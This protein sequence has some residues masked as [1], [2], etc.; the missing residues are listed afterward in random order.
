MSGCTTQYQICRTFCWDS[1]RLV[2]VWIHLGSPAQHFTAVRRIVF[3]VLTC[4]VSLS[5]PSTCWLTSLGMFLKMPPMHWKTVVTSK[6]VEW[7]SQA[8]GYLVQKG[9][10]ILLWTYKILVERE[11]QGQPGRDWSGVSSPV[12]QEKERKERRVARQQTALHCL[13]VTHLDWGGKVY[14]L[15]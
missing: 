3:F 12:S 4:R 9:S 15:T 8:V 7:V 14:V 5:L 1:L 6:P 10:K 2:S 11:T 13:P